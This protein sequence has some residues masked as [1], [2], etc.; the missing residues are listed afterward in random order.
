MATVT[1]AGQTVW[2][3]AATG[4]GR[5]RAR[6]FGPQ[7]RLVPEALPGNEGIIL[8]DLGKDPG[9]V[10]LPLRYWMT[11][12]EM[13]AVEAVLVIVA[14]AGV[15]GTLAI[16][17][18]I[19]YAHC[20]LLSRQWDEGDPLEEDDSGTIAYERRLDLVFQRVR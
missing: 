13:A 7:R 10:Y 9:L 2:N 6:S 18:G 3:D 12:A 11:P 15:E 1:F 19:S 16:P 14:G 5:V 17:R 4:R 20:V 8:K